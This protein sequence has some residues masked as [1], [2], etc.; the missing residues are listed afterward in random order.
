MHGAGAGAYPGGLWKVPSRRRRLYHPKAKGFITE[1][2]AR[3]DL[4]G[5]ILRVHILA[6]ISGGIVVLNGKFRA[7]MEAVQAQGALFFHPN[8][9]ADLVFLCCNKPAILKFAN[10]FRRKTI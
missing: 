6:V 2:P 9:L 3:E 5:E 1:N 10:R 7:N 4:G 8:R